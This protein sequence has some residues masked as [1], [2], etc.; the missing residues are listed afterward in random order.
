MK[1]QKIIKEALDLIEKLDKLESTIKHIRA[2][3][4]KVGY[5]LKNENVNYG[6][7]PIPGVAD[8]IALA[9]NAKDAGIRLDQ[10]IMLSAEENK[11]LDG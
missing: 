1:D 6:T 2:Q 7:L 4:V 10:L 5:A 9:S 3:A 11:Q 8:L